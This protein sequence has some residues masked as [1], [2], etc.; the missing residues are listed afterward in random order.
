MAQVA[1]YLL[2]LQA[3]G[4]MFNASTIKKKKKIKTASWLQGKQTSL[5][6]ARVD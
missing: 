5:S 6:Q 2:A 4:P 1:Y 3:L